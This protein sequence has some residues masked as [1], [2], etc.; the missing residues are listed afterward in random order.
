MFKIFHI[1]SSQYLINPCHRIIWP[2][3]SRGVAR[4]TI[5]LLI[6]KVNSNNPTVIFEYVTQ[7]LI[8]YG[9]WNILPINPF[10]CLNM[11]PDEFDIVEFTPPDKPIMFAKST[12]EMS[13]WIW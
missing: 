9:G 1:P 4:D 5:N 3:H 8:E 7:G 13:L 2:F 11:S 6:E 12:P 10:L